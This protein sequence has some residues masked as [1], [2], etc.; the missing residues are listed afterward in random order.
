MADTPVWM[1][2]A[3]DEA[4]TQYVGTGLL[5]GG[6]WRLFTNNFT[7]NGSS[8][9]G[10]FTEASWTGYAA[11][12]GVTWSSPGGTGGIS[13]SDSSTIVWPVDIAATPATVYGIFATD[14][15]G[16]VMIHAVRFDTPLVPTAGIDVEAIVR[17]RI[18]TP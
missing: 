7:P 8:V 18:R 9:V 10:D 2:D 14:S 17:L 12:N 3:V 13:H 5:T 15:S 4:L 6:Y 11:Q 1:Q 16:T